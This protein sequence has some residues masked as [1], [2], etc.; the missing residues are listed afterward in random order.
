MMVTTS[1]QARITSSR[2]ERELVGSSAQCDFNHRKLRLL[3]SP[4]GVVKI[5][6]GYVNVEARPRGLRPEDSNSRDVKI[7]I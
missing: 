6:Q 7:E 2:K 4:P 1:E 5:R 3:G